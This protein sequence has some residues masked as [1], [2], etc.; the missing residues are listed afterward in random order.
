MA[1]DAAW[2]FDA[3]GI[4]SAHV[5]GAPM[6]GMIAQSFAIQYPERVRTL[7]PIMSTTG[8]PVGQ[9]HPDVF[10]A[11]LASAPTDR[12]DVVAE[13]I[14]GASSWII[15]G[16]GHDLPPELFEEMADRVA[17]LARG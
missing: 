17:V 7:V 15:P 12:A 10:E 11:L 8:D 5:L 14:P 1:D 6:G 4:P 13:A 2:L 3:L 9:P 16:I